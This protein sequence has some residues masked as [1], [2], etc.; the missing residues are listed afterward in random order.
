MGLHLTV[1]ESELKFEN[2]PE[3]NWI[4]YLIG[5]LPSEINHLATRENEEDSQYYSRVKHMMLK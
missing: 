4:P 3:T 1:F 2:I 5:S